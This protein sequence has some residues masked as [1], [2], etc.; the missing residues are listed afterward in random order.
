MG[1]ESPS[2]RSSDSFKQRDQRGSTRRVS[3]NG[4]QN[5]NLILQHQG[6]MKKKAPPAPRP[7]PNGDDSSSSGGGSNVNIY[8]HIR[9]AS[10]PAP[11]PTYAQVERK[12]SNAKAS[13]HLRNNSVDFVSHS[14]N[15]TGHVSEIGV[16]STSTLP[17]HQ[18]QHAQA[19]AVAAPPAF[20][21]G[22]AVY[23]S[24]QR[25]R[26]SIPPP[27]LPPHQTKPAHRQSN[28]QSHD[29]LPSLPPEQ[30][31]V[32]DGSRLVPVPPPRKVHVGYCI[33]SLTE[34]HC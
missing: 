22:Q 20:A 5:H 8:A 3:A 23:S 19:I 9:Q 33:S 10:D 13:S 18:K 28:G 34:F 27:P 30:E 16:K 4:P 26:P 12:R 2:S 21:Q 7:K 17:A 11:M 14:N 15:G 1:S 6:S 31:I 25:P 29:S 24:L 32:V